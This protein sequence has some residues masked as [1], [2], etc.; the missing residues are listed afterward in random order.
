MTHQDA[1]FTVS[2]AKYAKGMMAVQCHRVDGYKTRAMMLCDGLNG[3]Y[4]GRENAYILSPRKAE[5]LK[6][7]FE[8]GWD[9][10][11]FCKKGESPFFQTN[12]SKG[13]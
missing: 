5:R 12:S 1:G 10:H 7:L 3:R 4:S 13:E 8:G 9:A 11:Y 6:E 2:K